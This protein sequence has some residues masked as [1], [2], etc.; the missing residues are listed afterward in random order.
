MQWLPERKRQQEQQPLPVVHWCHHLHCHM[1]QLTTPTYLIHTW[2]RRHHLTLLPLH[3]PPPSY[4][5][6][7]CYICSNPWHMPST[8]VPSC[9]LGVREG[10]RWKISLASL[11][12]PRLLW[13]FKCKIYYSCLTSLKLDT[14]QRPGISP[15]S[16]ITNTFYALSPVTYF[17]Q[18]SWLTWWK[19]TIGRIFQ[20][21]IPMVR[22][23]DFFLLSLYVFSRPRGLDD[24][25]NLCTPS[26]LLRWTNNFRSFSIT[27]SLFTMQ[28][29]CQWCIFESEI[30]LEWERVVKSVFSVLD[31]QFF[32]LM[33]QTGFKIAVKEEEERE[34]KSLSLPH[35]L[36]LTDWLTVPSVFGSVCYPCFSEHQN[37]LSHPHW[38]VRKERAREWKTCFIYPASCSSFSQ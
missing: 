3:L 6:P 9:A 37:P 36:P 30:R 8:L 16:H 26:H 10:R 4:Q 15:S 11:V 25:Q 34:T 7:L 23:F 12:L 38:H 29:H 32:W 33:S 13:R 31:E 24:S 1:N 5:G 19:H 27:L 21:Y 28:F 22:S 17:K 14:L 20:L 18:G 2:I 35:S